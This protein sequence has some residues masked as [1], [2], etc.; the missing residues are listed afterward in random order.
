MRTFLLATILCMGVSAMAQQENEMQYNS[1]LGLK[2]SGGVALSYKRFMK[3]IQAVE[4]Q[5][6]IFNEGMRF[7]GLYEF[8]QPINVPGLTWYVGPG[9][10]VGLW[11]KTSRVKYNS[12]ADVGIDGVLGL[13]YKVPGVPLN[14]SVDWQPGYSFLGAGLQPQFG[15]LGIRYVLE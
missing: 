2:I 14:L 15:G 6:M 12:R 9:A 4:A 13:D 1:A 7:T 8:H 3:S 5:G 11:T 10:H